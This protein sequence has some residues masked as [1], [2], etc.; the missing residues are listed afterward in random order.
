LGWKKK[1]LTRIM[2]SVRNSDHVKSITLPSLSN[3][4]QGQI[5][6]FSLEH[7][8]STVGEKVIYN[9]GGCI[10]YAEMLKSNGELWDMHSDN[11]ND[12]RGFSMVSPGGTSDT[13]VGTFL[14][15]L[16]LESLYQDEHSLSGLDIYNSLQFNIKKD[17]VTEIDTVDIFGEYSSRIT[18]DFNN[19]GEIGAKDNWVGTDNKKQQ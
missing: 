4:T 6:E 14:M 17:S 3:R 5:T 10:P 11:L 18:I 15:E 13:D 9:K 19:D 8:G 7:D 16:D 12:Q 1:Y 2:A